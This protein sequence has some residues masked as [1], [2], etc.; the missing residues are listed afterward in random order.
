MEIVFLSF[1]FFILCITVLLLYLAI[2]VNH[3]FYWPVALLIYIFSYLTSYLIGMFTVGL[4][5]VAL[6]LAVGYTFGWI[7]NR[8]SF[9]SFLSLGAVG[10]F[11]M[12]YYV[13]DYLF[14]PF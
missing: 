1:V 4:T 8:S 2:K 10:G 13:R 12:V 14:Y 3:Q 9:I 5:F 7:K 6:S 11:L